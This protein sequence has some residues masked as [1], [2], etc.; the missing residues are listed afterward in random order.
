MALIADIIAKALKDA[1]VYVTEG[2][3]VP[4]DYYNPSL[5]ML[6]DIISELNT[7]SAIQFGQRMDVVSVTGNKLTFKEITEDEQDI[8]DGG[9]SVDLTDRMTDFVPIVNPVAYYDGH[10]LDYI[11]LRDLAD[12]NDSSSCVSCY[13]FNVGEDYSE[14]IFNAP[15]GGSVKIIRNVPITIDDE[16]YGE[17]HIPKSFVLYLVTRLSEAIAIR[18]QLTDTA[19]I[20]AQKADR[21]G[22]ILANNNT[23][24][25]PI[26]RNL[27]DGLNRFNKQW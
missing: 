5:S 12:R 22:N 14:L 6:R 9:G 26:N 3:S 17:V 15:V 11:S 24:R 16:P 27:M 1:G 23:S 10:H 25:R 13:A 8:I 20:F 4:G 21:T 19:S 2:E 18:Y 7:Q